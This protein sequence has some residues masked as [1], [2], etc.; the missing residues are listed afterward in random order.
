MCRP[1]PN[2]PLFPYTTLSG[3]SNRLHV[4]A[5]PRRSVH[6]HLGV[7]PDAARLLVL[8]HSQ[9]AGLAAAREHA[10]L[11]AGL[12]VVVHEALHGRLVAVNRRLGV[13]APAVYDDGLHRRALLVL[14]DGED[15]GL[16]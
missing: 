11:S 8:L 12:E 6:R 2:P 1:P 15:D 16:R 9:G 3:P 5:E 13:D 4:P 10:V 14:R 7:K